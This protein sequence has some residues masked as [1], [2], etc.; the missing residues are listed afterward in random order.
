MSGGERRERLLE[1]AERV[2]TRDGVAAGTTRAIVA[3]AGM[4][5]SVFHYCF[6]SRDEMISELILRLGG[7]ERAAVWEA[8]VPSPDLREMLRSAV[9]AY[10][11]HLTAHP[12]QELVLLELNHYALRTPGLRH[13]AVQQYQMYY[14]SARHV[15]ALAAEVIGYSWRLGD[16]A[17]A[18]LAV[19]ILDGVT[20]TWLAYRDSEA[21]RAVL[22]N[23]LDH[24]A[25][26][27]V[28]LADPVAH[29]AGPVEPSGS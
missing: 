1:A 7:R 19:T 2:M 24:V 9:D 6:R 10:L 22:A 23:L 20:T 17:M 5:P 27:A 18:R 15:L 25:T 12:E 4:A 29:P 21:A 3:E 28:P 14:E 8:V 13:L 16:A 26:L 11:G